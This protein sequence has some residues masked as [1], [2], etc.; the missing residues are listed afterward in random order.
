RL[1]RVAG[2]LVLLAER[3]DEAD[4]L[5]A[6]RRRR[7][8]GGLYEGLLVLQVRPSGR[9]RGVVREVVE[10]LVVVLEDE[11]RTLGVLVLRV[12]IMVRVRAGRP[13]PVR[14]ARPVDVAVRV[15]PATGV[16]RPVDRLR[17]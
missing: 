10:R 1:A 13:G 5:Q 2:M 11:V 4:G 8:L 16:P 15:R 6:A 12:G 7:A 17:V 9:A 14:P 3:L